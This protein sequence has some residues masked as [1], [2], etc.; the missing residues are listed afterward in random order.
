MIRL[1]A[2]S[3][4]RLAE[5]DHAAVLGLVANRSPA[6]MVAVLLSPF[7]V[8]AGRLDMPQRRR[9]DPHVSPGR[10]DRQ[11]FI[12][13]LRQDLS[14]RASAGH[15]S[16]GN[17]TTCRTACGR[18]REAVARVPQTRGP[19]SG[20][21]INRGHADWNVGNSLAHVKRNF[22]N[23]MPPRGGVMVPLGH[24]G[25]CTARVRFAMQRSVAEP[26]ASRNWHGNCMK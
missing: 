6:G 3:R 10:R 25:S 23:R 1:L 20:R 14:G 16:P 17:G 18:C 22:A 24:D 4:Q 8:S 12:S 5:G 11:A 15:P 13:I 19:G 7:L 2:D 21:G 26:V 9:T